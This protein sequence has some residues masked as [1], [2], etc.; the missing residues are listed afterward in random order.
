MR[1][2][3]VGQLPRALLRKAGYDV[4]RFHAGLSAADSRRLQVLAK[5][6]VDVVLDVGASEGNYAEKLRHSGYAG[7]IIS[8]EPLATSY[9]RLSAAASQDGQWETVHTAIGDHDGTTVI[10]VSAR[11]TSSSLLRME[12]TH[13][14]AAPD[15]PYV[16]EEEISVRQL[17]SVLEG[18][19][20]PTDR[21]YL[22]IDV[23]G[24]ESWVLAGAQATLAKTQALEVEVS[25][26]SLYEGST[27]YVDMIQT[28][29]AL[30]FDLISWEDVF[31]DPDTGFVLQSDC[32][33]ARRRNPSSGA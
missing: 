12:P 21:F 18:L 24:Y 26:I 3:R 25:M 10:N 31:M 19:V 15:S 13:V 28:I 5:H 16:S 9:G 20:A 33:F 22:K 8:F 30:G 4:V 23:Q 17:D 11:S 32:I 1:L 14:A 7:R 29:D 27:L 6:H 2:S